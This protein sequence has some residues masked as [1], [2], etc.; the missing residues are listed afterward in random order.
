M[1]TF[2]RRILFV[3]GLSPAI[4]EGELESHFSQHCEVN[5]VKLMKDKKT[6]LPKG[7]AYVYLKQEPDCL[8]QILSM[9]HTVGGRKV[10]VQAASKKCDKQQ[11]KAEQQERRVFI[12]NLPNDATPEQLE[13]LFGRYGKVKNA[14][15]IYD[16]YTGKPKGQGYLHFE[17]T[18]SVQM[19]LQSKTFINGE[20]ISC[21]PYVGR[22]DKA[23]G[24]FESSKSSHHFPSQPSELR[25]AS[26]H[27]SD[28]LTSEPQSPQDGY[29]ASTTKNQAT[30][31]YKPS[32]PYQTFQAAQVV[33]SQDHQ[34][35]TKEHQVQARATGGSQH[36][37]A[38]RFRPPCIQNFPSE[39]SQVGSFGVRRRQGTVKILA[40][41]RHSREEEAEQDS[42]KETGSESADG[43]SPRSCPN[44]GGLPRALVDDSYAK[45]RFSHKF[46]LRSFAERFC[47]SSGHQ[48]DI[49][50]GYLPLQFLL[51]L[52]DRTSS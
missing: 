48:N 10:D 29:Y 23:N 17:D 35:W 3:G 28:T 21:L 47:S 49:K 8:D 43:E 18:E 31:V 36:Y 14:Y 4:T 1:E 38:P 39:E 40:E 44:G 37:Q 5:G 16:Y 12:R 25:K 15:L 20:P 42:Q 34:E 6:K 7:Y 52:A 11:W 9:F 30:Q 26:R 22:H 24:K 32:Q 33:F 19:A 41:C 46:S 27:T 45:L 13:A 51:R 2:E 50:D